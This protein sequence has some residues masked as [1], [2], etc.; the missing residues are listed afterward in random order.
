MSLLKLAI[1]GQFPHTVFT[2]K[3]GRFGNMCI[4]CAVLRCDLWRWRI[5]T[6]QWVTCL[7]TVLYR[8]CTVQPTVTT[9]IYQL[10]EVKISIFAFFFFISCSHI[11]KLIIW[12]II[13]YNSLHAVVCLSVVG[14]LICLIV[15]TPVIYCHYSIIFLIAFFIYIYFMVIL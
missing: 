9:K 1:R 7:V 14:M 11:N 6:W 8:H 15:I 5:H 12:I 2:F 4:L 13:T 10:Q 3:L